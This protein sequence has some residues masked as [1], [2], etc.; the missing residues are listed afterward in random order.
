[1]SLPTPIARH[2]A[3]VAR[4]VVLF[5]V[6][7]VAVVALA[8]GGVVLAANALSPGV[9]PETAA[10]SVT[11]VSVPLPATIEALPA[12]EFSTVPRETELCEV[13]GVQEA[14]ERGDSE[15]VVL[16]AGGGSAFREAIAND[17]M[18]CIDLSDP[19][20]LWFVVNKQRPFEQIDWEP[21][22]LGDI[23]GIVN[24]NG[25]VIR[26]VATGPLAEL[27]NAAATSGSGAVGV[28][29]GYRS[30]D[31]QVATFES[32]V[33]N[34][35]T[36]AAELESARPGYSE[37]QSGLTVDLVPCS[38]GGCESMESMGSTTQGAWLHDH[39]WKYGWIVRYEADQTHVTGYVGEAW[40]MRY[41]GVELATA[42]HEGGF[43]TLEDFFGL[44]AAP[45]Y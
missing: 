15:A 36:A 4:P 30:Y 13:P 19:D 32:E 23:S 3:H 34:V 14:L 43:H 26:S 12:P 8:V 10:Q 20:K 24:I 40:H 29:S 2:R 18:P 11:D 16:A 22:D 1:M 5:G 42:Y 38:A 37:H 28:A 7:I 41:I 6:A 33:D 44:P 31:T 21:T 35:G 45:E 39:A 27:A 17:A 25:T 9:E